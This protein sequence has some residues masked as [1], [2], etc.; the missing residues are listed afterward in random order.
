MR[1]ED[2]AAVPEATLPPMPRPVPGAVP[3]LVGRVRLLLVAAAPAA[4]AVPDLV[5]RER[6][7]HVG[8]GGA[9]AAALVALV[10]AL[11][12]ARLLRTV[13]LPLLPDELLP[14]REGDSSVAAA[15]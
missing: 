7:V 11:G 5:A 3:D 1:L 6:V 2:W 4:A 8:G 14:V 12:F 15:A 10:A 9:A 13:L